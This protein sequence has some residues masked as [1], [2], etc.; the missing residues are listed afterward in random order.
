MDQLYIDFQARQGADFPPHFVL[1]AVYSRLHRQLASMGTQQVAVSF[2]AMQ[3]PEGGPCTLG[4]RLRLLGPPAELDRL[5]QPGWLAGTRDLVAWQPPAAVPP[6]VPQRSLRRVQAQSNPDRLRRRLM[7]RHQLH[8]DE[9]HSRIPDG[10]AQQLA[11]PYLHV[12][13]SSTGQRFR[14]FL[15]LGPEEPAAIPGLFNT[16]GLSKE[17]TIPWF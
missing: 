1:A 3:Q 16:Y 9:A 2:P 14:L 13:S 7:K 10:C 4:D 12:T 15:K 11:L 8:A 6:G 5:A 17:A